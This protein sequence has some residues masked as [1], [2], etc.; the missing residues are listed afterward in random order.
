MDYW[1]LGRFQGFGKLRAWFCR[2]LKDADMR[3]Q[4]SLIR[5]R[6][7]LTVHPQ[8]TV[9]ASA[10]SGYERYSIH[11]PREVNK[12]EELVP[13]VLRSGGTDGDRSEHLWR[14]LPATHTLDCDSSPFPPLVPSS[15]TNLSLKPQQGYAPSS[16][17]RLIPQYSTTI[18][19]HSPQLPP[20]IHSPQ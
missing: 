5:R 16:P 20:A 13:R 11:A 4:T 6:S 7:S 8:S 18:F 9:C 17:Q 10:R 1:S 14:M 12:L 3:L 15:P 19:C 2:R